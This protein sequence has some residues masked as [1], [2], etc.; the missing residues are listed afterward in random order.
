M[1]KSVLLAG[2][3]ALGFSPVPITADA[4]AA[5]V[6]R[7]ATISITGTINRKSNFRLPLRCQ[8]WITHY[9]S[10]DNYRE[11]AENTVTFRGDIGTCRL[12]IP[13]R[14]VSANN[15]QG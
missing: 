12:P 9:A 1:M 15:T 2:A 8:A 11:T 7:S 10:P 3:I 13:F 4:V 14:W 6:D 5:V